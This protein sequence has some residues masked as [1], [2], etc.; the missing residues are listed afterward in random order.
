MA[1]K[2]DA[3]V[4]VIGENVVAEY[5]SL[6]NLPLTDTDSDLVSRYILYFVNFIFKNFY[7]V[8]VHYNRGYSREQ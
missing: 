4:P 8:I 5:V 3:V 7:I 2:N 6:A 1:E